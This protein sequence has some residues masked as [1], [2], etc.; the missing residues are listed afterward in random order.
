MDKKLNKAGIT[1]ALFHNLESKVSR[2]EAAELVDTVFDEMRRAITRGGKLMI[3]GFGVF[4]V[5]EKAGRVGRNPQTGERLPIAAR[6]VVRFKVSAA[7][8]GRMN[9]VAGEPD[10]RGQDCHEND[11]Y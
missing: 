9:A 10:H 11:R 4:D 8:R 7:L 1:D 3:S 5:R 6:R 2:G